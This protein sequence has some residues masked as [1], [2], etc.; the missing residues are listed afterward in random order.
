M[1][2]PG[3][4]EMQKIK[5]DL[6]LTIDFLKSGSFRHLTVRQAWLLFL[7][8]L[9]VIIMQ[10]KIPFKPEPTGSRKKE[11]RLALFTAMHTSIRV[12][13]HL[14]ESFP[15]RPEDGSLD[16]NGIFE[17]TRYK[18]RFELSNYNFSNANGIKKLED[19][20]IEEGG[21]PLRSLIVS[22][23]RSGTT[24][25]G[26]VLNAIPGNFYHYEPLLKYEIIQIRGPPYADE[27]LNTL[28]KYV[29]MLNLK[30]VFL[31]RDP[32]GVMQS[33]Q[34][35][36]FCQPAPD[37]WQPQLLCADM[38]NDYTATI[39]LQK[40]YPGQLIGFHVITIDA[41]RHQVKSVGGAA[42]VVEP[43]CTVECVS[44]I[45]D[46]CG[47]SSD[48][49]PQLSRRRSRHLYSLVFIGGVVFFL[50]SGVI[51]SSSSEFSFIWRSWVKVLVR[52]RAL[53]QHT[54]AHALL[55]MRIPVGGGRR[56]PGI[57]SGN[58]RGRG[59]REQTWPRT[60]PPAQVRLAIRVSGPLHTVQAA[61]R[62]PSDLNGPPTAAV[63][64]VRIGDPLHA[65]LTEHIA[66]RRSGFPCIQEQQSRQHASAIRC[67]HTSRSSGILHDWRSRS[68]RRGK[69]TA[70]AAFNV[71]RAWRAAVPVCFISTSV[72]VAL[73]RA[74][75]FGA[76]RARSVTRTRAGTPAL[77]P[78]GVGRDLNDT[79]SCRRYS[80]RRSH[81]RERRLSGGSE[82]HVRRLSISATVC[83]AAPS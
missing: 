52:V 26:E 78:V 40:S 15:T 11:A 3:V 27:A 73:L 7:I 64:A 65:D 20:L 10:P 36:N 83:A 9:E 60:S 12:V 57:R 81:S 77:A 74:S 23:W 1:S 62:H 50:R 30:V 67:L 35:R 59:R 43:L 22:T 5:E 49:R 18:I 32:R 63:K 4:N 42:S 6:A 39:R 71:R 8:V 21:R 44:V 41:T 33:R 24:F 79:T 76:R 34:H 37:C 46:P 56:A 61:Y 82:P 19:L 13:D 72:T 75:R 28:K 48:I 45:G 70:A 68:P 31:V 2:P 14:G 69:R 55:R 25:L 17:R 47:R 58:R 80:R 38:V 53:N 16:V 51:L 54:G 29:Q 66:H